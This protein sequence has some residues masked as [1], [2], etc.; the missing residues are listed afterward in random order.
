MKRW[1]WIGVVV[2]LGLLSLGAVSRAQGPDLEP[3]ERGDFGHRGGDRMLAMLDN[4]RVR[5]TL[6]LSDEQASRLRQVMVDAQKAGLKTRA[7]LGVRRIELRELLRAD[8]PDRDAVMKKVQEISELRGQLMKQR[9]DSLLASK[10]ILTPEQQQ[11]MRAFMRRRAGERF[12]TSE[13][14]GGREGFRGRRMF[15]R[16]LPREPMSPENPAVPTPP[17][18][19]PPGDGANL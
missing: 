16:R 11:K 2:M 13:G 3:G 9:I 4:E 8:Q 12:R 6:G 19:P 1:T 17:V 18:P 7:D 15:E 5:T 14:F 10:A